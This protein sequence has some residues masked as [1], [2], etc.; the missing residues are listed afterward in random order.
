MHRLFVG[1]LATDYCVCA[2]VRDLR[3]HA[4]TVILL[5]DAIRAVNVQQDH[6][7]RALRLMQ[8]RGAKLFQPYALS[9]AAHP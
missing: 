4:F 5:T 7:A 6:E 9:A 8:A 3:A 1:G 2:T